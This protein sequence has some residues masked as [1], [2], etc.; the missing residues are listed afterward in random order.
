[1]GLI[2]I[3]GNS[4]KMADSEATSVEMVDLAYSEEQ[5]GQSHSSSGPSSA[6]TPFRLVRSTAIG[7]DV[8]TPGKM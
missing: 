8:A 1:M 3:C 5:E 2:V 7:S 6:N 4:A